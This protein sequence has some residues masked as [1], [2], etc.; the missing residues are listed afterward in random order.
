MQL[1]VVMMG[2]AWLMEAP[3]RILLSMPDAANTSGPHD[4]AFR[5]NET[6]RGFLHI[7]TAFL[8]VW[9]AHDVGASLERM[10]ER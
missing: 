10:L 9:Q 7:L 2:L 8:Y 6:A 1:Y 4:P 5:D 3:A